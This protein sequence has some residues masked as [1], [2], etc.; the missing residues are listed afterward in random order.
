MDS[1]FV[2]LFL[3]EYFP[4]NFGG[5]QN[6]SLKTF[7]V[8]SLLPYIAKGILQIKLRFPGLKAGRLFWIP[9]IGLI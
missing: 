3:D 6:N 5:W 2:T 7:R 1:A 4:S 8:K 9:Q